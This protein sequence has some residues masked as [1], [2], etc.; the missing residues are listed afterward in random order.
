[1]VDFE[2]I[3]RSKDLL[4]PRVKEESKKRSDNAWAKK[5]PDKHKI[6]RKKYEKTPLGKGT[7][8][9][10]SFRRRQRMEI[11]C[12]DLSTEERKAIGEF[13]LNCPPG[14]EVD[15]ILPV[16]K[17]GTH[18]LDNLQYLTAS[19][20]RSKSAK[21]FHDHCEDISSKQMLDLNMEE[22]RTFLPWLLKKISKKSSRLPW[23]QRAIAPRPI[24]CESVKSAIKWLKST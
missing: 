20:N 12:F 4:A 11:E 24:S 22:M 14:Y 3:S 23:I 15:H 18:T 19:Q 21:T 9:L 2:F 6:V 13:Y 10:N 5:N 16:A 17:G 1:M 7:V 8:S